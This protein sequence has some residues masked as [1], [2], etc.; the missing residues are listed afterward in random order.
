MQSFDSISRIGKIVLFAFFLDI[1]LGT[2]SRL[3]CRNL[4]KFL[5]NCEMKK[6]KISEQGEN[7]DKRRDLWPICVTVV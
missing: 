1:K 6:L 5:S 3:K 7:M 4:N 2:F